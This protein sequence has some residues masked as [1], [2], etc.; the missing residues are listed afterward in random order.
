MIVVAL[1]LTWLQALAG[2]P[3]YYIGTTLLVG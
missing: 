3:L 1:A 2:L